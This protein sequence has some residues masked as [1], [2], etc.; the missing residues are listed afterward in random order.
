MS[1]LKLRP[2]FRLE[3]NNP[4]VEVVDI[5]RNKLKYDN[6]HLFES[7]IVEGHLIL[8]ICKKDRHFW[9][10]QMDISVQAMEEGGTLIRG[11]LAPEPSVWT[12]F[13]FVYAATAFTAFIGLMISMSQ[14]T[15]ERDMW[16][17]YLLV[18]ASALGIIAYL[19]AQSGKKIAH[20]EMNILRSFITDINWDLK[21]NPAD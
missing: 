1:E 12:M 11:L 18:T 3:V 10:P 7:T 21:K 8:R 2:R 17:I 20:K 4:E 16:G 5:V 15:L 13:M 19:V 6:A 14:W 9:S